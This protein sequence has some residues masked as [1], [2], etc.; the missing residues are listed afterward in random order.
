MVD[1]TRQR[2]LSIGLALL[3]G[4]CL[5][6]C[7]G[8][9]S[10]PGSTPTGP[11]PSGPTT[12]TVTLDAP[13]DQ[14]VFS[15]TVARLALGTAA[16]VRMRWL[17]NNVAAGESFGHAILFW[18]L[19]S[20]DEA[21]EDRVQAGLAIGFQWVRDEVFQVVSRQPNGGYVTSTRQVRIPAGSQITVRVTRNPD[22]TAALLLGNEAVATLPADGLDYLAA[23]VV[24]VGVEFTYTGGTLSLGTGAGGPGVAGVGRRCGACPVS[25]PS[26]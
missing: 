15:G 1:V 24:G 25:V 14:F 7:G 20:P 17:R 13:S 12:T 6:A 22:S 26:F 10:S 19:P 11:T 9:S 5:A 23:E 2:F 3:L 18:M 4:T 21:L 8:N 16:D